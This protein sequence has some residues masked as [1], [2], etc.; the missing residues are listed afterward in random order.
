MLKINIFNRFFFETIIAGTTTT[1][2]TI[3]ANGNTLLIPIFERTTAK[4]NSIGT[5]NMATT[6]NSDCPAINGQSN[7]I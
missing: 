6:H 3:P 2:F 7:P 5:N 4:S 1:T